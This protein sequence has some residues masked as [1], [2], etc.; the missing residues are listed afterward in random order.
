MMVVGNA[1]VGKTTLCQKIGFLK[2]QP[3]EEQMR[4]SNHC[5][6][7][8]GRDYLILF[9]LTSRESFADAELWFKD[10]ARVAND[11]LLVG[12]KLDLTADR[13]VSAAEAAALADR[14]AVRYVEISALTGANVDAIMQRPIYAEKIVIVPPQQR[15]SA[16]F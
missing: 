12:N 6:F 3:S 5:H 1:G 7:R 10:I 15:R 16:C 4:Y 8:A 9:D 13:R 2:D 14:L 11:V